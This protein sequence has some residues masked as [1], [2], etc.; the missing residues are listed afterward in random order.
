[1]IDWWPVIL[2]AV[3]TGVLMPLAIGA[4]TIGHDAPQGGRK[5]HD[6]PTSRLGGLIVV[7]AYL[8]VVAVAQ[9]SANSA[10]SAI[11]P[12]ALA[13]LPVALVGLW[14]DLTGSVRPRYRM[15]AAVLSAA[16]ASYY[17]GGVVPR[18]DLPVIDGLLKHLWIVL[19]LT[20]FM[21]A[22]ACNAFNLIDGSNG[23]AGGTALIMFSGIAA[24]AGWSGDAATLAEALSVMGILAGFMLWNY[25][26]GRVF[27]GDAGAYFIGFMYAELSI[28]LI[29]RNDQISAWY[30]IMVAGYPIVDT[31]VAMYRRGIVRRVPLMAPDALHL[32]SLIY[33]R[34]AMPIERRQKE[35]NLQRANARV[36]PRLWLHSAL[37]LGLA[38]AF[39]DNTPALWVCLAVY[40]AIH[41]YLYR[42][43]VRFGRK[44]RPP[45]TE[46]L[47][48]VDDEAKPQL[49]ADT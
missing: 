20:G 12:L 44:R 42:R 29:T 24:A 28:R 18:V 34:V 1:L 2:S 8:A 35:M 36:A 41:L 33:R 45:W 48:G 46:A 38:F 49:G 39:Q 32:H 17:A 5:L 6:S 16:L 31:L 30:V 3:C 14:E 22:G 25:P 26:R 9:R 13:A 7:V 4:R 40:A 19:P 10:L 15:G 27:L 21:V 23:L 37:C 47:N 43:L 11:L